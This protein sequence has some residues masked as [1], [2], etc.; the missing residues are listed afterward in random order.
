MEGKNNRGPTERE[1]EREKLEGKNHKLE[2]KN[3]GWGRP[4]KTDM[5]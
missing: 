1:R 2:G 3:N 4:R 5:V